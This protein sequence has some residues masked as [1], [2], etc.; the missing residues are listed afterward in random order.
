MKAKYDKDYDYKNGCIELLNGITDR[1]I[2]WQVYRL[3][4]NITKED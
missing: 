1:W 2:L 3:I 4:I